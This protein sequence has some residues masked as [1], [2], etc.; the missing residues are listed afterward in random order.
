METMQDYAVS[1]ADELRELEKA[2]ASDEHDWESFI[3]YVNETVLEQIVWRS[4]AGH[5]RVE[6]L[7]T[8]GGPGCRIYFEADEYATVEAYDS[9]GKGSVLVYC[10]ELAY[11]V[12]ELASA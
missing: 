11:N 3:N 12:I 9:E 2:L 5:I 7:R 6:W 1:I 10:P 4:D 8:Y